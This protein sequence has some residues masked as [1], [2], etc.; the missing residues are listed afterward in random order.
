VLANLV[1]VGDGF[2]A[3]AGVGLAE[4]EGR[5]SRRQPASQVASSSCSGLQVMNVWPA[6]SRDPP[7]PA[8]PPAGR[9]P[10]RAG[11]VLEG[12]D[13]PVLGLDR[14]EPGQ[15]GALHELEHGVVGGPKLCLDTRPT[16]ARAWSP[17]HLVIWSSGHAGRSATVSVISA[18]QSSSGQVAAATVDLYGSDG[19]RRLATGVDVPVAC[20]IG[21][22]RPVVGGQSRATEDGC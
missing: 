2:G 20:P 17:G 21:E 10:L 12:C 18:G 11:V 3:G 6:S 14:R 19:H 9:R 4:Q 22:S 13:D 7:L 1:F 5:G 15:A 16:I 8:G